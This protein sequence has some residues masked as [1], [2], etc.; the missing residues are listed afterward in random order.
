MPIE[1]ELTGI[2]V[3]NFIRMAADS[4]S[5]DPR[6]VKNLSKKKFIIN[7]TKNT[8]NHSA[9]EKRV[10]RLTH[11]TQIVSNHFQENENQNSKHDSNRHFSIASNELSG[12]NHNQILSSDW[13]GQN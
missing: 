10:D 6:N 2:F 1:I 9:M 4:S 12:K 8:T 11:F 3:G 7:N 13:I 5:G